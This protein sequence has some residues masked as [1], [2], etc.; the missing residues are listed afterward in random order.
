M[1]KS[2]SAMLIGSLLPPVSSGAALEHIHR[3]HSEKERREGQ[4]LALKARIDELNAAITLCQEKLP[5]SG[6]PVT[7]Q[8]RAT[9]DNNARDR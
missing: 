9:W 6:A 5:A 8:V 2:K 7:K 3:C 1:E 4:M